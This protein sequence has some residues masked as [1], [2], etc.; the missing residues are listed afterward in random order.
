MKIL[1]PMN[2]TRF[3]VFI[4]SFFA[5]FSKINAQDCSSLTLN[6]GIDKTIFCGDSVILY[7]TTNYSY[8]DSISWTWSP[9]LDIS[10][11]NVRNPIVSPSQSIRYYVTMTT[12]SCQLTDSIE[13]VV[14]N[15]QIALGKNR[16]L[17]CGEFITHYS[18]T[19][20]QKLNSFSSLQFNGIHIPAKDT[21]YLCGA[22]GKVYKTTDAG[23]SWIDISTTVS[24]DLL[25]TY[26]LNANTGFVY[27]NNGLIQKTSN[28][29]QS[30]QNA[31]TG[32]S[33]AIRDMFFVDSQLG[34]AAG[35]SGT[36][37][38]YIFKTTNAGNNWSSIGLPNSNK[39]NALHFVNQ[40]TG[41]AVCEQGIVMKTTN[42]GILWQNNQLSLNNNLKDIFFFDS[43]NGLLCGSNGLIMKTSN[44]GINWQKTN[45]NTSK[46]I[47][48][49]HT[50]NN[51]EIYAVG[52]E[53]LLLYSPN[54]GNE[55]YVI[56]DM[57]SESL[58]SIYLFNENQ[59]FAVGN[60]GT[61]LKKIAL[62]ENFEWTPSQGISNINGANT[63]IS[64]SESTMYT[65][66]ATTPNGCQAIDSIFI[67][68][69]SSKV[70][71]NVDKTVI[72]GE[73]L[74]LYGDFEW[75]TIDFGTNKKMEQVVAVG[76]TQNVIYGDSILKIFNNGEYIEAYKIG[77]GNG[78][79]FKTL[80]HNTNDVYAA[81][82]FN[83]VLAVS[84][85]GGYIWEYIITGN[86][87]NINRVK[88]KDTDFAMAVC[89][90]GIILKSIDGGN[91]WN[92]SNSG[93]I[94]N[95]NAISFAPNGTIFIVGNDGLVL[96]S[97]NDGGSFGA[98]GSFTSHHLRDVKMIDNQ[99]GFICGDEGSLFKTND[100]GLSWIELQTVALQNF[101]SI[102]FSDA[103]T[104]YVS[105]NNGLILKSIDGG[106]AW[107]EMKT[108]TT[109]TLNSISFSSFRSG[110]AV[111]NNGTLLRYDYPFSLNTWSNNQNAQTI[112]GDV[113]E[114]FP[115][116]TTVYYFSME[117]NQG[118]YD[119]D[120]V[121]VTVSPLLVS[122]GG[123]IMPICGSSVELHAETN[124]SSEENISFE[125]I[126]STYLSNADTS[127]PIC[128]PL[129]NIH[130]EVQVTHPNGCM[131]S[132]S[133]W[134]YVASTI[135]TA[136]NDTTIFCGQSVQL[137]ATVSDMLP[138]TTF[139]WQPSASLNNP[140][141]QNPTASPSD[142]TIYIVTAT[143]PNGCSGTDSL[144][145]FVI[146]LT[147]SLP[148]SADLHCGE[149]IQLSPSVNN[150]NIGQLNWEWSPQTGLNNPFIADPL[151]S[152]GGEITYTVTV[153]N[154]SGECTASAIVHI[155]PLAA[156][157]EP[158]ICVASYE[159]IHDKNIVQ[160]SV[161]ASNVL[162]SIS[163]FKRN[164]WG[165]MIKQRSQ[166][167]QSGNVWIDPHTV[168]HYGS[169]EYQ[170]KIT[171]SCGFTSDF[172]DS[173]K[174]IFAELSLTEENFWN[175][176]W[177]SYAGFYPLGYDIYRSYDRQD[178]ERIGSVPNSQFIY[179]DTARKEGFTT[180]FVAAV[181]EDT[182]YTMTNTFRTMSVSNTVSNRPI[183]VTNDFKIYPIP[184]ID[185][186][187]LSGSDLVGADID[188]YD[189]K[190][191]IVYRGISTE[192]AITIDISNLR[193]GLFYLQIENDIR[194]IHE[195]FI[196]L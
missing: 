48:K 183:F 151:V 146:P 54:Q 60:S 102:Y 82:G 170:I 166:K 35:G 160:W 156:L 93:Y 115:A 64:P 109:N 145:I 114:P 40:D 50:I 73:E 51:Y 116:H 86:T 91:S 46:Q 135:V 185:K 108:N 28:G 85:N 41:Y 52:S 98:L 100:G 89:D 3:L 21:A 47:Y 74:K 180:Y 179:I 44:G 22:S 118:C 132:D 96:K 133:M 36:T 153:S 94:K 18:N 101:N 177:S 29:G 119:I 163:I 139:L 154:Q 112:S 26:F 121:T 76:N 193:K 37:T 195:K 27:G 84:K 191:Q 45:S 127:N 134:V 56:P 136:S 79:L 144:I 173:H 103:Q 11:L 83:G 17:S 128:T 10:Q 143:N 106:E 5:F 171:D 4:F 187:I 59:A 149:S 71:A 13:I 138:G 157:I 130:Y 172:S 140:E 117:T 164:Q 104:I 194:I 188:I 159:L 99:T 72:C 165:E 24:Y 126:P 155:E 105:G 92:Y 49:F 120:S 168:A 68:V 122:C 186:I 167:M 110:I 81:G 67:E 6:A 147:I 88:F 158:E 175:I 178:Y 129:T 15:P 62:F 97:T 189:S 31:P 69:L 80:D 14:L 12:P 39:I 95:L 148:T 34:F 63:S 111:G 107:Y 1:K 58:N 87:Q 123:D 20:W 23:A 32:H 2:H 124:L 53:G 9:N 42:A 19:D 142:T 113:L 43:E 169:A 190:G 33:Q 161:P 16:I 57:T 192:S 75:K 174:T 38:T 141:I 137:N 162:D 90:Q 181:K 131:A 182:C 65:L 150:P 196:K 152:Y 78:L 8:I 30:W 7:A 77:N 25:G 184:A 125:W 61:I 70:Y 55:W 176:T 66:T